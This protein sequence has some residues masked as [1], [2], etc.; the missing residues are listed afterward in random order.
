MHQ[1]V[2]QQSALVASHLQYRPVDMLQVGTCAW[3][4]SSLK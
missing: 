2:Q 3:N 4:V 1:A